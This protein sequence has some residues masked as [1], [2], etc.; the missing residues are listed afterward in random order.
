MSVHT[1]L[2]QSRP[3]PVQFRLL[4]CRNQ[5]GAIAIHPTDGLERL[6]VE[7]RAGVYAV[8]A[9][10]TGKGNLRVEIGDRHAD[11]LIGSSKSALGGYD[12]G[13]A[14]Q[15]VQGLIYITLLSLFLDQQTVQK[16]R[17]VLRRSVD[18]KGRLG[19]RQLSGPA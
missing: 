12:V 19:L 9:E 14:A 5:T 10:R 4:P 1:S 16:R 2:Q 11:S 17:A 18:R 15:N 8:E 3:G 7:K 6:S 13:P